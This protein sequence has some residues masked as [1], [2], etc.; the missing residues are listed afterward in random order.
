MIG[1]SPRKHLQPVRGRSC[2]SAGAPVRNPRRFP[3]SAPV[4]RARAQAPRAE[5]APQEGSGACLPP[6]RL[7]RSHPTRRAIILTA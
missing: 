7:A 4:R 1:L 3:A 5:G 6:E 2:G